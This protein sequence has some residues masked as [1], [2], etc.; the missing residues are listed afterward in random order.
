MPRDADA[1]ETTFMPVTILHQ[2]RTDQMVDSKRL[3][4]I[5]EKNRD[6][7]RT[8]G[9]M[10]LTLSGIMISTSVAVVLFLIQFKGVRLLCVGF[11]FCASLMFLLAAC[12]GIFSCFLKTAHVITTE[13][14]FVSD[15]VA[16]LNSELRLLRVSFVVLVLGILAM[17]T[18]I[19][20]QYLLS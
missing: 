3:I 5:I 18:G 20:I 6:R 19:L 10:L 7:T 1:A 8:T 16:L 9:N 14:K 17:L 4:E 2:S 13:E 11:V 15:L 12:L